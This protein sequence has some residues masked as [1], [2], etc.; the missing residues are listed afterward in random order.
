MLYKLNQ[1][2]M[3]FNYTHHVRRWLCCKHKI[4]RSMA[5]GWAGADF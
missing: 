4:C 3:D 5:R 2:V 1:I